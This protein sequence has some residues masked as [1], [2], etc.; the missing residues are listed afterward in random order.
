MKKFLNISILLIAIPVLCSWTWFWQ[1]E[2]KDTPSE[3]SRLELDGRLE[4]GNLLFDLKIK[5]KAGNDGV[6]IEILSGDVVLIEETLG[7]Q[8]KLIQN[9]KQLC[10]KFEK[11]ADVNF[12]LTFAVKKNLE[13]GQYSAGFK[14]PD[15]Q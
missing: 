13:K 5:I 11:T 14:I 10:V 9:N 12:K 4:K 8:G 3:I 7:Q 6:P 15:F 2:K 1:T